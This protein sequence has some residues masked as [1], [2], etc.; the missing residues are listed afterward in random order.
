[1]AS[2]FGPAF[3]KLELAVLDAQRSKQSLNCK[4]IVGLAGDILAHQRGV[5]Q[6]VR[7]V[8]AGGAG[9]KSQASSAGITTMAEDI[10]PGAII[11]RAGGFGANPRSVVEQLADGDA[12]FARV[13]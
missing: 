2:I 7:R 6:R 9:V 4:L 8:T 12:G 1:M 5:G 10:F 13:A 11:G 3:V